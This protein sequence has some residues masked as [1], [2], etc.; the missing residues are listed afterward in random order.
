VLDLRPIA[1]VNGV[2]LTTLGTAMLVPAIVD[3][4]YGNDDWV[5]FVSAATLT[6]FVGMCLTFTG[7]Q[8]GPTRLSIRQAFLLTTLAWVVVSGFAALP[9][10]FSEF[11]PSY[12]GAYFEAMSALT[13]TGSTVLVGLDNGPPGVLIWRALLQG[14][15]GIGI[16]V[17]AI[18]ILPMLQIGGMQLFRTESSDRS[19]KMLPRATQISAAITA[20]YVFLA[21]CLVV[22]FSL[23]GMSLFDAVAHAL[24][25]ISTGGFSTKD[26]SIA[27]FG[28]PAVEW[29]AIVGMLLGSLP[30]LAYL[31]FVRG[32]PG[33][34]FK[35][36]Q[37]RVFFGIV[38]AFTLALW[39][40]VEFRDLA[41]GHDAIRWALFNIV[42]LISTTGFVAVDYT[43]WGPFSDALL[44]LVM[45]LGACSGSTAGGVKTFR[46]M[47]AWE[48]VK[49]ALFKSVYPS[50][51]FVA[52]Y[53][54]RSIDDQVMTSV[55]MFLALYAL[56]F[57]LS[58][59][60]IAAWGYDLLTAFSAAL[61]CLSNVG[62][63]LGPLIGP[64]GNFKDFPDP[65]L[66][67]LSF[68]MLVGRLELFT[69][70]VLFL[71]RFWRG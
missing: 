22:A 52:R 43:N 70:L 46:W 33:A 37:I 59:L 17:L 45:F 4:V 34:F 60:I 61:T 2:L 13:T 20:I 14:L 16:I 48:G 8:G 5:V 42:T 15:G 66:W 56:I 36:S 23:A 53:Q 65:I 18:A 64:A 58:G 21:V 68:L 29:V 40:Y 41:H 30:F 39:A 31:H 10:W 71:P 63:G 11:R 24:P 12:A 19:E 28:S 32:K 51:V 25:A 27:A 9:I 67:L 26:S 1:S 62:P 38:A 3:V 6:I 7:R 57:A 35:D 69:V 50:S 44:F 54:G 47:I 49:K 55:M